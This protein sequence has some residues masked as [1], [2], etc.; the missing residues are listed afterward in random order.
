MFKNRNVGFFLK[1][2]IWIMIKNKKDLMQ[3]KDKEILNNIKIYQP[4]FLKKKNLNTM[5]KI[6]LL[7]LVGLIIL[8]K[9]EF[10]VKARALIYYLK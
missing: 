5:I 6:I 2:N 8:T 4:K 3:K 7:D 10:G 1:D 9:K